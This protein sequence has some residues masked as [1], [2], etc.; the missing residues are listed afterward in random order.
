MV[1]VDDVQDS[2]VH[3]GK[4]DLFVGPSLRIQE[5]FVRLDISAATFQDFAL[6][7]VIGVH[8]KNHDRLEIGE[9]LQFFA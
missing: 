3:V 5:G 8:A 4:G 2:G 6:K 7:L 9:L 1:G